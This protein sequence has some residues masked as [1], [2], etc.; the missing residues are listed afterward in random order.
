[1]TTDEQSQTQPT[2]A[3]EAA[4]TSKGGPASKKPR[5]IPTAAKSAPQADSKKRKKNV[6]Q[7]PPKTSRPGSKSAKVIALLKRP[8]GSTLA[9]LMKATGWQ[10]H[11]V[12]GFLAGTLNKKLG[13]KLE[14]KKPEKGDRVYSIR[15]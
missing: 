6:S 5:R 14:S 13:L 9:Q 1:M 10:A 7:P 15:R 11:S 12:R 3:S 4:T 2:A 8:S